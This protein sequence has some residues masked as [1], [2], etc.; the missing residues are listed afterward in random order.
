MSII[1]ALLET[2]RLVIVLSCIGFLGGEIIPSLWRMSEHCPAV[3]SLTTDRRV[4]SYEGVLTRRYPGRRSRP[5]RV[6]ATAVDRRP[7]SDI[8]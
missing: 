1:T 6:L 3:I 5:A 2:D 4:S 8:L 7:S